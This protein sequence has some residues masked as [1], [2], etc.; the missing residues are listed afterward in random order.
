MDSIGIRLVV[1]S[2]IFVWVFTFILE[3][4]MIPIVQTV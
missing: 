2:K 4:E 3:G 1:L